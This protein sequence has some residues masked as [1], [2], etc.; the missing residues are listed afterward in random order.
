MTRGGRPA[1]IIVKMRIAIFS[2]GRFHV[3]DLARELAAL[4]H[5]VQFYS[6]VPRRRAEQFGLPSSCH[7]SLLPFVLPLVALQRRGPK[8]W[9]KKL[10]PLVQLVMDHA[11]AM[12][13]EACDVF[14]GMSGMSFR[15]ALAARKKYG[16][17]VILE[18][19][20]RH[21]LS[22][23][24]V[25]EAIPSML[26][27]VVPEFNLRRELAGY[28][29]ADVV[30]IPSRHV[31][32]SFL[33]LGF[34]A[35]RLFRN[36]YGVDLRMF[37]PTEKP[38][39]AVP[40]LIFAGTWSLRKGCDVLVRALAGQP[41]RLIHVGAV[42]DAPLPHLANF[43]SRGFVPQAQ[44][45]GVYAQADAFVHPSREEGLS[46]VQAQALACGLPLVCTD[47]TGGEDLAEF[48][49][50][51][52][53]VTVVPSDDPAALQS[54]IR[55]ALARADQQTG[56]RNLLGAGRERLSWREYGERY[57]NFLHQCRP[58]L[59]DGSP[60]ASGARGTPMRK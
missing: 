3:L 46:L 47:R 35:A 5:D 33:E 56:V 54:G 16:A 19:G 44:L 27:P 34:P 49:E 6:Y 38:K 51:P 31:E 9:A 42:G 7:R 1:E 24:A 10:D 40:T 13:L 12:R 20:S 14:I 50:D 29:F 4:G 58:A 25:L 30:T 17:T 18:R 39:N 52:T 32:R 11:V 60:D 41:W 22:Q 36:P 28:E 59:N 21:I 8:S 37:P 2:S 57:S 15:S 53:W 23:K 55:S 45:A 48:L 26:R 43:E